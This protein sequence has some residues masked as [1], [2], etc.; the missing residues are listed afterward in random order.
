M[1]PW[2]KLK[3]KLRHGNSVF[4][5][6]LVSIRETILILSSLTHSY[7]QCTS[8]AIFTDSKLSIKAL[9]NDGSAGLLVYVGYSDPAIN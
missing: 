3:W 2:I 1:N 5:A 8:I 9:T 6:E 7:L 4:Q